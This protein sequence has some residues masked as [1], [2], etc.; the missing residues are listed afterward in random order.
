M[1]LNLNQLR[2]NDLAQA[3][4]YVEQELDQHGTISPDE[5][6]SLALLQ[7]DD[8]AYWERLAALLAARKKAGKAVPPDDD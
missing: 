5:V 7:N 4:A 6:R 3:L 1:N 8:E 2:R